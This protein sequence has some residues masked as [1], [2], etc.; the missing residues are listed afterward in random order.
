VQAIL[1]DYEARSTNKISDP[2]YGK[3]REPLL[4]VTATARAFPAPPGMS[5]TYTENGTQT[6]TV[7]TPS[8]H[9]MNN[10]DIVSL[11]FTDTSGNP[12]PPSQAY[13]VT[14]TGTNVF[15]VTAP[16]LLTG[17]YAETNGVITV[18]ISNHGL[19]PGNVAYL[20]FTTG[21]AAS[22]GYQV[23]ATNSTSVFTVNALD[24]FNRAGN[25][26]MPRVTASGYVQSGTNVTVSCA[27]PHGLV[28]GGTIYVPANSVLLNS[29][30]Y[31]INTIPD[32]LHFTFYVTNSA[33]TTQSGFNVYPLDPPPLTR[34]GTVAIQQS[35][36]NLG[37]TDTGSTYS[38]TQSPLRSPTVFNFFF[39]NYE[40]PGALASAGL[41]TPEFQLTSDTSVALA[42]NFLES[43]VLNNAGN[44]NGLSSF[45]AGG[46]A[47]VLDLG[48]W[49]TTNFTANATVPNLVSN[50]NT[51][52]LAGQLSVG[53]QTNIVNYVTNLTNF[54]FS[55]PPTTSQMRDRVR[56]V[57]HLIMCSPDFT[58]QK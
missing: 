35:T 48:P 14:A 43:G 34:S 6:I 12:A 37:Y 23:V 54:P 24:N 55:T 8:A 30:L 13:S 3:Q 50:L 16:N 51:T 44:T 18:T 33:S 22:G 19:Q 2:T 17:S 45:T 57:V 27:G 53:A 5:G 4:R 38:L 26:V 39:P 25:C 46:G 52:L 56:A 47:I 1:L 36:W 15:T 10:G 49:M 40:F 29:G 58:I 7:T 20:V 11:A 32:P 21:G 28:V 31:Q 42:M 41:T 9:R